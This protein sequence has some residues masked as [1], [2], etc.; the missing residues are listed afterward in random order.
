MISTLRTR[1]LRSAKALHW[2]LALALSLLI[3]TASFGQVTAGSAGISGVVRDPSG[4]SVAG[5][6]VVVSNQALGIVRNLTTNVDGV[7]NAP[8]L[9]PS[10]GYS[11]AVTA[12]GFSNW[13][14]K[15]LDLV[16]GQNVN[17]PVG[18]KLAT[19]ATQVDVTAVAPL[20]EDTKT[21]VSQVIGG[22]EIDQL[23]INGRRVDSFVLLTP[24]VSNDGFFGN[25][26]FR[27]MPENNSYLV[28]GVDTTEQFLNMNGGRTRIGS[29]I[30][31]DAVQEFQVV[32][33]NVTA[34]F[35]RASGGVVNTVTRSGT[36]DIHGTAYWFFRNRTLNARDRYATVNPPEVRHQAGASIGGPIKKDKLFYFLNT[37]VQRRSF[38]MASSL[39]KS[40]LIDSNAQT[41][42]GCGSP[43]TPAQCA[44]INALLPRFF[45]MLPR[46]ADQ[47]VAF[48]KL[49]YR[50]SDRHSF[51]ASFNFMHFV[52]P[53]G[54]Q[55]AISS[56]TGSAITSNGDDFVRVRVGRL[57]WTSIPK[58]NMVNEFR[59]GWFTDRQADDFNSGAETAGLGHLMLSVGGQALGAG[60]SYLPR[61][62]PNE[63]RYQYADSLSWIVGKHAIKF[64]ADIA[65]TH[66]YNLYVSNQFGSY[67][68]STVTAFAQDF[69]DNVT[70][71]KRWQSFSQSYGKPAVEFTI[72]DHGFYLQDQYR[73]LPKLTLN[74]GLR[75]D[76]AALPQPAIF[77]PDYPLTNQIPSGT[78]NLA[79]RLGAA[80]SLDSK[81]VLRAGFGTYHARYSGTLVSSLLTNNAV[82]QS[83]VYVASSNSA[84]GPVFPNKLTTSN[85]ASSTTVEFA[86]PSLRTPYTEQGTFAIERQIIPN[87]GLT[88]SY[89]WNRG[90]Q[91]L[92]VRDLNIGPLGG[93]VVYKIAD[94]SGAIVGAYATPVYLLANRV[95]TR[96]QRVLQ[97]ENGVNSYYNA[98]VLQLRKRFSKGYQAS[99]SYTWGHA[100]DYKQGTYQDNYG[101]STIDSYANSWNGN[102]KADKGSSLVD[103][104]H[105]MVAN[106]V[107]QPKFVNRDGAMYKY[108][109]NNWQFSGIVT[110]SSGRP[111]TSYVYV[112]G[113][114][115]PGFAFYSA[116]GFG[117]NSRVPFWPTAA[118]YTPPAYRADLRLSKIL[119]F[120]ERYRLYLNFE[121][122][123]V[124]NSQVDT[125]LRGQAYTLA[126]GTF[127]PYSTY[128][129][130]YQTYGTPDG[131]NARRFQVS[132]R[133]TF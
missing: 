66:D 18:M 67:S 78:L 86:A 34:E 40:G 5:A 12:A 91:G 83:S 41:F 80:Y 87:L 117:G 118:L 3:C 19:A 17:L 81:T 32:S 35:G 100:I 24:G 101:F 44:A 53:N 56:N 10:A 37:E 128:G 54:I 97:V 73:V 68:Y 93:P 59:F 96:Y 90:I 51:N 77:N 94:A 98:L 48:G 38:P 2:I 104:R 49:D 103:Q 58:S 124:T 107:A 20:V 6:K 119:P 23:P 16:V 65:F 108:A 71:G 50:P 70:G 14:M 21:D 25:L 110:L 115:Y 120:T 64:G 69:T 123:N 111:V 79:P 55:S 132:A 95:D 47:E 4:A 1:Q 92:G 114:P 27:G 61:I 39:V 26:T 122:F 121:G 74:Y 130:G 116:N 106:F 72:R 31:Q 28:D 42:I 63:S 43:A 102:Y 45:G 7:F 22:Q 126:G 8:A 11:V 127:T 82:Y 85:L 30:G 57:G 129:Q 105:R 9:T 84:V 131:T 109:I 36:N 99:L 133:F 113:S 89:L 75:Y 60:A 125:G 88:V 112:S 76:Y 33:S 46:R 29:Q 13:T 15:D 52:S 62:N